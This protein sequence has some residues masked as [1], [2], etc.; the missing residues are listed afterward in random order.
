MKILLSTPVV[1]HGAFYAWGHAD[2]KALGHE[3]SSYDPDEHMEQY[4]IEIARRILLYRIA[5]ECPQVLLSFHPYDLIRPWEADQIRAMGCVI[6]GFGYDCPIFLDSY[7][8]SGFPRILDEIRW[9][10]D[11][12]FSTSRQMVREANAVIPGLVRHIRW[13]IDT[14][15]EPARE[16]NIDVVIVGG[17]YPRRV[18]MVKSL[19]AQ[20]ITP[21]IYGWESWTNYPETK[22]LYRGMLTKAGVLEVHQRAK[23]AI[24]D[25]S[26]ESIYTPMIKLRALEIASGGA[27]LLQEETED[28]PDYFEA[29]DFY[30]S[31]PGSECVE[32]AP[33]DWA[34]LASDIKYLLKHDEVR[35]AIANKGH[36]RLLKDHTWRSRWPEVESIITPLLR[37]RQL[38]AGV[39]ANLP[40][41]MVSISA[42]HHYE[43]LGDFY[44]AHAAYLQLSDS[45]PTT[46]TAMI[47]VARA[48]FAAKNYAGAEVLFAQSVLLADGLCPLAIDSTMTQR[49]IGPRIGIGKQFP[50]IFPR[51]MES[52]SFLL[53]IYALTD[54]WLK[55][56]MLL[57]HLRSLSQDHLFVGIVALLSERGVDAEL[58]P[59][60]LDR[61]ASELIDSR[62]RVWDGEQKR[63]LGQ[64]FYLRARAL[65]YLDRHGESRECAEAGLKAKPYPQ[66]K[67]A[68]EKTLVA[69][70]EVAEKR[71][72]KDILEKTLAAANALI[73]LDEATAKRSSPKVDRDRMALVEAKAD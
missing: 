35:A 47:G 69:L 37:S 4:G 21:H 57:T 32:Y 9:T 22:P 16:R 38:P 24:A 2:L 64:F 25:S 19:V 3:V 29:T 10:Y 59:A 28:R 58:P 43:K 13:A 8:A 71:K 48:Q 42:A 54:Q 18:E 63:H 73:A 39:D 72:T 60:Y 15:P 1:S 66:V 34:E 41:D 7:K 53:C 17:A 70:D 61:F 56:D 68:L 20:G 23:I 27:L 52:Y 5:T 65:Y 26:W 12:F 14:P 30:A 40:A 11:V 6:V 49:K 33:R 36:L 44:T 62:P 46:F 31:E 67:D 45:T 50:G 51:A 55:C